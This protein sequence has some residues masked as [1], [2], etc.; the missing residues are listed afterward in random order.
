MPPP[1]KIVIYRGFKGF[2]LAEVLITL[3]IIGVV[4]AMTIPTLIANYQKKVL[5]NQFKKGYST[6][7]NIHLKLQNEYENVYN[8]FINQPY[9]DSSRLEFLKIYS[10][11]LNGAQVKKYSTAEYK[12]LQGIKQINIAPDCYRE[13]GIYTND[14]MLIFFGNNYRK[15]RIYIDINGNKRPNK[16]GYD[17]FAFNINEDDKLIPPGPSYSY[18]AVDKNGKPI[19]I[20]TND[21]NLDKADN[22][23]NGFGCATYALS[24]KC[25]D[26]SNREYW[27]CLP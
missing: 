11:Y 23:Y 15:N 3:G 9:S 1:E 17:L 14:G 18:A 2:T 25:P 7:A 22:S 12:T 21:C 27:K 5:E 8:T 13:Y 24:N 4:A 20:N 26:N 6:L 10:T 16:L 19:A